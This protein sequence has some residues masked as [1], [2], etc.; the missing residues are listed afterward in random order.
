MQHIHMPQQL[1]GEGETKTKS[2]LMK[3]KGQFLS[4]TE[5]HYSRNSRVLQNDGTQSDSFITAV[6]LTFLPLP[7]AGNLHTLI[8][9]LLLA[10]MTTEWRA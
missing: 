4:G 1:S 5:R 6:V 3:T 8:C 2:I 7:P 10:L 9:R